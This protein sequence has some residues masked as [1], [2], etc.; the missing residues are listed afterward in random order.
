MIIHVF[1]LF[2]LRIGMAT[3]PAEL[4][5]KIMFHVASSSQHSSAL[6]QVPQHCHA[7]SK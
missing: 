3:G 7:D 4:I 1:H 6:S 5:E 2:S